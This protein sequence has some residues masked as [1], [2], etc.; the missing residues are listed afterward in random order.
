MGYGD[1]LISGYLV[2]APYL[3]EGKRSDSNEDLC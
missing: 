2:I 3:W 1:M